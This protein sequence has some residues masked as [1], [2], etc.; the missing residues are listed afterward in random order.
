MSSLCRRS[1][2]INSKD[3]RKLIRN[4]LLVSGHWNSRIIT[5]LIDWIT[6]RTTLTS[7]IQK[8]IFAHQLAQTPHLTTG[9]T[10]TPSEVPPSPIINTSSCPPIVCSGR[11]GRP[12]RA[13]ILHA[14]GVSPLS[15]CLQWADNPP[16]L[17]PLLLQPHQLPVN[18]VSILLSVF[19]YTYNCGR[20][21]LYATLLAFL[22]KTRHCSGS[23]SSPHH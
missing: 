8:N 22:F 15:L 14:Q 20:P 23:P 3:P 7:H 5:E 21:D 2:T 11:G 10:V 13:N 6:H 18:S 17:F 16:Q 1:I 19:L 9:A 12:C 4:I